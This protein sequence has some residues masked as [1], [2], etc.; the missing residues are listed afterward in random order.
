[1]T[2]NP[3]REAARLLQINYRTAEKAWRAG[4]LVKQ[5]GQWHYT[6]GRAGRPRR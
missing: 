3:L 2:R 1:M 6:P 5:D 4:R